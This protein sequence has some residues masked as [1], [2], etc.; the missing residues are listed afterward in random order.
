MIVVRMMLAAMAAVG[1]SVGGYELGSKQGPSQPISTTVNVPDDHPLG[2]ALKTPVAQTMTASERDQLTRLA[3]NLK[4]DEEQAKSDA[5]IETAKVVYQLQDDPGQSKSR[6][7]DA[8]EK[9]KRLEAE[10]ARKSKQ[11]DSKTKEVQ[12]LKRKIAEARN[13][14][15]QINDGYF[16]IAK[17]GRT[18]VDGQEKFIDLRRD[19]EKQLTQKK[20]EDLY[21][22]YRDIALQQMTP[23]VSEK[24][25]Q[26]AASR[27][28]MDEEKGFGLLIALRNRDELKLTPRQVTQL[29]YLQ[30]DFIR[31]FA[32]IREAYETRVSNL[33]WNYVEPKTLVKPGTYF[34]IS[35][36]E[37]VDGVK[38]EYFVESAGKNKTRV[39]YWFYPAKPMVKGSK[40]EWKQVVPKE[41][42]S[43]DTIRYFVW[44]SDESLEGQLKTLKKE[45]DDKVMKLL[46]T[47]Q[48][49]RLQEKIDQ[50]LAAGK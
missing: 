32:P 8:N 33:K 6:I 29:Q 31:Q 26:V 46:S 14:K 3:I 17:N 15:D 49:Q 27:R 1:L 7:A 37:K 50:S 38:R 12:E 39:R 19:V 48:R 34:S 18:I 36:P 41:S 21:V 9:I 47:P 5:L 44:T 28:D 24:V 30:A 23:D 40:F 2:V 10:L 25:K 22:K 35:E 16:D 20:T 43:N 4:S 11:T 42:M 13:S 45:M